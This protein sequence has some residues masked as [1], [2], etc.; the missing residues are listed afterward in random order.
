MNLVVLGAKERAQVLAGLFVQCPKTGGFLLSLKKS[1]VRGNFEKC[2]LNSQDIDLEF[3]A[4]D[5]TVHQSTW[6][7]NGRYAI[8]LLRCSIVRGFSGDPGGSTTPI[9]I[10]EPL[11]IGPD[12]IREINNEYFYTEP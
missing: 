9:G 8:D 11:E 1:S 10:P 4:V 7:H 3:H 12:E 2:V 6:R 5:G